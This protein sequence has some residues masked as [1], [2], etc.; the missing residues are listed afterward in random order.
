MGQTHKTEALAFRIGL[1]FP[2]DVP[3]STAKH[4]K[5]LSLYVPVFIPTPDNCNWRAVTLGIPNYRDL[6]PPPSLKVGGILFLAGLLDK[7]RMLLGT[8]GLLNN[9]RVYK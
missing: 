4:R 7:R 2:A 9:R 3:W 5:A 1:V 6:P 8:L